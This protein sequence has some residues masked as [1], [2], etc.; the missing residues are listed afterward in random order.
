MFLAKSPILIKK[1]YSQLIWD[2]PNGENKILLA[3][4]VKGNSVSFM[5]NKP[6]WHYWQNLDKANK[7]KLLKELKS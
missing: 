4:T 3:N 7:S 6:E 2:I 5:E 1:Y